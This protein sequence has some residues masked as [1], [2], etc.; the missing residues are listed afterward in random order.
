M[1]LFI[2]TGVRGLPDLPAD[3]VGREGNLDPAAVEVPR[4]LEQPP[5]IASWGLAPDRIKFNRAV[6]I[7]AANWM[8]AHMHTLSTFGSLVLQGNL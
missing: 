7:L 4:G 3:A 1:G 8:H 2:L 5:A 6:F